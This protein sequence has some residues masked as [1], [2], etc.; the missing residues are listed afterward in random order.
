MPFCNLKS[1]YQVNLIQYFIHF[2][3]IHKTYKDSA[4]VLLFLM[5]ANTHKLFSP[6]GGFLTHFIWIDIMLCNKI[7][8]QI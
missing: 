2:E 3:R 6:H 7:D 8:L 1:I 4:A 5:C